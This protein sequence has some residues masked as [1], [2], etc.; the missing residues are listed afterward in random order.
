MKRNKHEEDVWPLSGM[1]SVKDLADL[2][3]AIDQSFIIAITD[4]RGII[5]EVNRKFCELSGY[6]REELIGRDHR[7]LNSGYHP[8]AFFRDLWRKIGAG[9]TWR[10]EIRNRAKD[11]SY[12]WVHTTIVPVLDDAGKPCRYISMRVEITEQKETEAALQKALKDDFRK[13]FRSAQRQLEENQLLYESLFKHS[14]DAV[15]TLD[16]GGHLVT[17]NPA[18]ENLFGY[19][20][21]DHALPFV[22]EPFRE[23]SRSYFRKAVQGELQNFDTALRAP[24]APRG[25]I[26]HLNLTLLP[27]IIDQEIT[28]VYAI[29]KDITEHKKVQQLNAFL[30]HHDEL[31]RLLNRRGFEVH[32]REAIAG[33]G[34]LAVMYIDLDRFKNVN[35]TLGH[36]IGDRL[37]E[38]ISFRLQTHTG[39]ED[40]IARMGGDEFMVLCPSISK[41]EAVSLARKLIQSMNEPFFIQEYELYVTASIGIS[42]Y[43]EH[44]DNVVELMKHAD[45]A[46]YKAKDGGRNSFQ[47]Y[48]PSMDESSY[49]SFFMERDLRKALNQQEFMIYF[50]PRVDVE[51][52]RLAGA[53]ALIRWHH[54]EYG[55][56]SPGNFIPLA[57]ETGLIILIGQY[58]KKSVCEQ[59]VQWR[60]A[61]L[62]L[63][64]V[65]IN[66]SAQRFLQKDFAQSFRQ[67]LAEYELDGRL[68]EI[69]ITENSLMKNEEYVKQTIGELKEM[70]IKIF[71][72]DFGTGYSSF[73]YLNTYK[74]DGLKIDQSFI[75]N[76]SAQSENASITSAM[77]KMAQLLNME[78]IAEGVE[79]RE[80]LEFL[81]EHGCHHVQGY[82]FGK[83]VCAAEFEKRLL[84]LK[85]L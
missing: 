9:G 30:A 24:R 72:D 50:Q 10:G 22:V 17:M 20:L 49:H 69:E 77:I 16:T 76:I 65:S 48:T 52:G 13:E 21:E 23:T 19:T 44:G 6:S 8:K 61:G 58:V 54:P 78:I 42:F 14:Q 64:P 55:I 45:V 3:A 37:L 2:K 32:L 83:P 60:S 85:G 35:D 75:R 57:E 73:S 40:K 1:D 25:E 80:E 39:A 7:I 82:F 70:G 81:R 41:K 67:L 4:H 29:G 74:L 31:T 66:I 38:Q 84:E 56:I 26:V 62:P 28:G 34:E 11:G 47:I 12:Y 71:I 5:E 15:F 27:I 43:P 46:M 51:S 68:L 18:A 36:Y 63:V 53:E 33:A 59:L 79:T